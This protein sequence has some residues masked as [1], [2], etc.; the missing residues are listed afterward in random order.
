MKKIKELFVKYKEIILYLI[1]GGLT[2]VIS[3]LLQW[4]FS[5]LVVMPFAWLTTLIAAFGSITFA[6]FA[7][8]IFVFESKEKKSFFKELW[9]FYLSRGLTMLLEVGAM[10]LFVDICLFNDW[11]VKIIANIVI[12][13]LNYVVSKFIVFKKDNKEGAEDKKENEDLEK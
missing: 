12:I 2:T 4:V 10:W 6:F 7:N 1:V 5:D 11:A 9:L 3:F 8:R 13:L